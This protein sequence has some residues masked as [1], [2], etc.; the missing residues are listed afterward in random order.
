MHS[1]Y[2][3]AADHQG[4]QTA[5]AA[6]RVGRG[7]IPQAAGAVPALN[8]NAWAPNCR[9]LSADRALSSG[10]ASREVLS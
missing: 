6:Y 9:L 2:R 5:K 3:S 4:N 7:W 1:E 10:F 8:P